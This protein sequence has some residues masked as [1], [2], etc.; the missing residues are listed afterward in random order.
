MLK[1]GLSL[2]AALELVAENSRYAG[3]LVWR[4]VVVEIRDGNS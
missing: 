1:A 4:K 2:L 3:R